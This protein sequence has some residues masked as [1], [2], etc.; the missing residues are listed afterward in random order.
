MHTV[1]AQ[2][3]A[4]PAPPHTD[5]AGRRALSGE[6][7]RGRGGEGGGPHLIILQRTASS[8]FGSPHLCAQMHSPSHAGAVPVVV[9]EHLM[10]TSA[11]VAMCRDF[12]TPQRPYY[13]LCTT[14]ERDSDDCHT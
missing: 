14:R 3:A 12:S 1:T 10:A 8:Q 11:V 4:V 9:R 7:E 2:H 6:G 13:T 5:G